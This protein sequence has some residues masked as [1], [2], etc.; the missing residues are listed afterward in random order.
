[1]A[2]TKCLE[3]MTAPFPARPWSA[4]RSGSSSRIVA[5]SRLII[6]LALSASTIAVGEPLLYK[7]LFDAFGSV[8]GTSAV[9]LLGALVVALLAREALRVAPRARRV[10]APH[11]AERRH[12]AC[13]GGP[14]AHASPRPSRGASRPGRVTARVERGVSGSV[15]AFAERSRCISCLR[16]RISCCRR[17]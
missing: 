3:R 11:H 9:L 12:A 17:S 14:V 8:M 5:I 15:A 16:S 13:D 7:A 4:P 10:E 2:A 1:M 6:V